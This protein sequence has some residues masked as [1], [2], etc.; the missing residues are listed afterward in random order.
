MKLNVG[1]NIVSSINFIM[2]SIPEDA[3]ELE[4]I[5]YIYI[6]LGKLFCYDYRII[7]DE[8]VAYEQV[9]YS[10]NEIGRYKTCY[11][12]SEIL[13]IL[14]NGMLP[15][16]KAKVIERKI[17]GRRFNKE[18]VGTE[19]TL[20]NGVKILL[21]LTL[22]L[23]NIQA[24]LKTKEFGYSNNA[25]GDYDIISLQECM[26]MDKKL[27]FIYDKYTD[28]YIEEFVSELSKEN[29]AGK[30]L[31]EIIDYK[32]N[33]AKQIFFKDFKGNYEAVRYIYTLFNKILSYDELKYLKQ[34]NLSYGNSSDI[35]LISSY[36]FNELG[37][38]YSYSNDLGFNRINPKTIHE[39]LKNGWKTNST[40]IY[41]IF[42][43][44]NGEDNKM[45]KT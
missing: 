14:I 11:Q 9:D 10:S 42:G 18:H 30:T 36:S 12:I 43:D 1:H 32:I 35:N 31:A 4:K 45:I 39:L 21:D 22:D 26:K 15:E 41:N 19:V 23:S 6:N 38:Y 29:F 17:P 28:D 20:S 44:V 34:H 8:S 33:K 7:I 5:R 37:L 2:S 16:C 40:S 3:T 27:G 13:T 25:D 24:G